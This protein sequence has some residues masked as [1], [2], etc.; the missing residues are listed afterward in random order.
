MLKAFAINPELP[1]GLAFNTSIYTR[2]PFYKDEGMYEGEL[3]DLLLGCARDACVTYEIDE[4]WNAD[5]DELG[6]RKFY[7]N[8][9]MTST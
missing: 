3:R 2:E 8:F 6:V 9:L 5:L 1:K 7:D 4:Q